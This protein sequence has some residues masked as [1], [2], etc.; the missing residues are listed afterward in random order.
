MF[1]FILEPWVVGDMMTLGLIE[2]IEEEEYDEDDDEEVQDA[3][4]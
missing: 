1:D 2:E 3:D 4:F